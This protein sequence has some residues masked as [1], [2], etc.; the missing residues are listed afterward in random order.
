[1]KPNKKKILLVIPTFSI[2]GMERVMSELAK[3]FLKRGNDVFLLFLVKHTPFYPVPDG[4][5]CFYPEREYGEPGQ[6]RPFYWIYI[7]KYLRNIVKRVKPDT[8][9]SIPQ[10]YSNV[11]I[12]ALLGTKTP[13]YISDRNSPNLPV[14]VLK[15][16]A[17]QI[18]YPF[19]KGIIAQTNAAKQNML[20]M[21]IKNNNIR[22]IPNPLKK[23]GI[24][25]R[26]DCDKLIVVNIGRLVMEK[27]QLELI[28]IFAQLDNPQWEL[29]I[30][31]SGPMKTVL[32]EKIDEL[33][34]GCRIKLIGQVE[35]VDSEMAKAKI[36]AFTSI[37]EGF[38]NSLIEA[39]AYPLACISYD[40]VAGPSD[41]IEDG[42]NGFLVPQGNQEEYKKK[43]S[44]LMESNTL[45][46]QFQKES[47]SIRQKLSIENVGDDFLKFILPK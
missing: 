10:D 9:L 34:I 43:L 31:G 20:E 22:V 40:C 41:I 33:D 32:Q 27:N 30:V 26:T 1:M 7:L 8:V 18:L 6:F 17:R 11:T 24:D 25:Q 35:D 19:A 13:V 23:I 47:I 36:F 2:G 15:K 42:V 39:M 3:H 16:T 5:V 12:L 38:P 44:K 21:G 28:D 37:Y 29:H 45:R 46:N 4:V 14:P